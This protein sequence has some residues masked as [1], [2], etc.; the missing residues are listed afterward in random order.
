VEGMPRASC[1]EGVERGGA[2]KGVSMAGLWKQGKLRAD[3][4]EE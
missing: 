4:R 2:R 3:Y 1:C